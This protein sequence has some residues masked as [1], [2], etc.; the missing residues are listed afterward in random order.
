M[1]QERL[2][3]SRSLHFASDQI[4]F[5]CYGHFRSED[6]FRASGRYDSLHL[7]SKPKPTKGSDVNDADSMFRGPALWY[8]ILSDYTKRELTKRSD[9]LPALS[10]L[11]RIMEGQIGDRYMAGLWRS[12]LLEGILWQAIGTHRGATS[13]PLDYRAPSWSWASIDGL[14]GNLGIGKEIRRTG[15]DTEWVDIGTILDCHVEVKG[16]NV[17]G[18]VTSGWIQMTAPVEALTRSEEKE[19]DH[20]TV[21][22]KRALRMKTR[23]GEP[24]GAYCMLDTL[25]DEA[26]LE[27]S[28][29]AMPLAYLE[30][31]EDGRSFQALMIT[32]VGGQPGHYR[33]VGKMILDDESLGDCDWK[34]QTKMETL[35]LV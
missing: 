19:P 34:D 31:K 21:P 26:A 22:H 9:K 33:R 13:A 35:T 20:E 14:A 11:A 32:P 25:S 17:Y 4:F 3:A 28:L 23:S 8:H 2:L 12:T 18:E 27:L 1:L 10:G 5:E 16:E 15:G 29:F 7:D 6:G 30:R 24:F